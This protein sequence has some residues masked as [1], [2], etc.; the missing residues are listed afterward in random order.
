MDLIDIEKTDD[1]EDETARGIRVAR[2]ALVFT[3]R[4]FSITRGSLTDA[5]LV[6]RQALLAEAVEKS[7]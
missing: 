3:Q 1:V 5:T 6:E 7:A 2:E 4:L